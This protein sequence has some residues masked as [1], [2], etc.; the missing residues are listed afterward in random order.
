MSVRRNVSRG[1]VLVRASARPNSLRS[2]AWMNG[3]GLAPINDV[4]RGAE[5]FVRLR[6]CVADATFEV[7]DQRDFAGVFDDAA[8]TR[9]ADRQRPLR[10]TLFGQVEHLQNR[11]ARFARRIAQH[12]RVDR[13]PDFASV[14]ADE[15]TLEADVRI[16]LRHQ[17]V[18]LGAD[19]VPD[20]LV[21]QLIETAADQRL[22]GFPDQV[23]ECVVGMHDRAAAY[24]RAPWRPARAQTLRESVRCRGCAGAD[25]RSAARRHPVQARPQQLA[26][27]DL[28]QRC[29]DP[30]RRRRRDSVGTRCDTV[31]KQGAADD[32]TAVMGAARE[33]ASPNR[34]SDAAISGPLVHCGHGDAAPQSHDR[35]TR[36]ATG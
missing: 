14:A 12:P 10:A 8:E 2:T 6:V 35:H 7:D 13:R 21:Q 25:P 26:R 3:S 19:F 4:A 18:A 34:N 15:F 5:D 11:E 32:E 36:V 17:F 22:V 27:A 28:Q 16:L 24:R 31:A 33:R 30:A 20:R 1:R 29:G 9:L 23:D